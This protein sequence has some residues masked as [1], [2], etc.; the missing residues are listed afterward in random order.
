MAKDSEKTQRCIHVARV[1]IKR[2]VACLQGALEVADSSARQILFMRTFFKC[3]NDVGAFGSGSCQF[4]KERVTC[5]RRSWRVGMF[6]TWPCEECLSH[7]LR[8]HVDF[9]SLW[10]S[11]TVS[12]NRLYFFYCNQ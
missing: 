6:G 1:G 12:S 5:L 3:R 2:G 4:E 11:R 10:M 7:L 8:F 9:T